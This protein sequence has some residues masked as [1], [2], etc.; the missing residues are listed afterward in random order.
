MLCCA[1]KAG[2]HAAPG[3]ASSGHHLAHGVAFPSP[4]STPQWSTP[5]GIMMRCIIWSGDIIDPTWDCPPVMKG[6]LICM[7]VSGTGCP[8]CQNWNGLF[9]TIYINRN[10]HSCSNPSNL[11]MYV[12]VFSPRGNIAAGLE[13]VLPWAHWADAAVSWLVRVSLVDHLRARDGEVPEPIEV[14]AA[15]VVW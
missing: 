13:Q 1:V 3:A 7:S 12:K 14:R 2:Q 15:E 10:G 5:V 6:K 4:C 11:I 8:G 9:K